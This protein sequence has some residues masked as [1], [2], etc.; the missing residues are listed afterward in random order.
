MI[1][2]PI[3]ALLLTAVITSCSTSEQPASDKKATMNHLQNEQSPYL[4]QHADNPVDWYPWGAEAFDQAQRLN[5][6]IFLSI[7][8]ST[9]HWCHVM[10]HESFEDET[11]AKLLNENFV[12]IKV[13]REE[14]PEI[15]HLY[16]TVCQTMTGSGGWPLT[17]IMTPDKEPFFAGTYFPRSAR[18]G[19]T[20]MLELLPAISDAWNNRQVDI[21]K[22]V[23]Q[24]K[25]H[26]TQIIPQKLG[27]ALTPEIHDQTMEFFRNRFDEKLG[28]FG[29]A[30]KFPSPHN[31]LYLM[32][33]YHFSNDSAA[34]AMVEKTL[35]AI[36]YGGIYDHLGF[37]VHRYSTD[38]KWLV[39]HFEKMLY[40]QAMLTLAYLEIYQITGNQFYAETAREIL[41]YVTR[42]MTDQNGGFYSA[43]D[44]D[45]EGEEGK[46]YVWTRSEII[47]ILGVESRSKFCQLL[48][49][50]TDGNFRNEGG[51][52]ESPVNIPHLTLGA[53]IGKDDLHLIAN[54]RSQL[55]AVRNQR[56][57]PFKDDKILTD[58]NGL[59]IAAFAKAAVILADPQYVKIAATAAGFIKANLNKSN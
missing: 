50:K 51:E 30:P 41:A 33:Y 13:D 4:L 44:A 17:I 39:P 46:F 37:G 29:S 10:E 25:N 47:D 57:R 21:Q 24:I 18:F 19:R 49:I 16:M 34:L 48:N 32:R 52:S 11:V 9:C 36:R 6:P 15:D 56:I 58:W 53:N 35:Q 28:G 40:D 55:L 8:Y 54:A 3:Q 7:G 1:I 2:K 27:T 45:S 42:D 5:R 43:E 38:S 31:L 59:M 12:A 22:S 23:A 14:L 20:G 26:L